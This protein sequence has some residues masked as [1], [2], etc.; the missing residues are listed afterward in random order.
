MSDGYEDI[1]P[2]LMRVEES[3]GVVYLVFDMSGDPA[4]IDNFIA[5][6]NAIGDPP[7]PE[8]RKIH[9]N[10]AQLDVPASSPENVQLINIDNKT[11]AIGEVVMKWP[12]YASGED[13]T[14]SAIKGHLV[15]HMYK[16]RVSAMPGFNT[17]YKQASTNSVTWSTMDPKREDK[18]V[19]SIAYL[20]LSDSYD[21]IPKELAL[22]KLVL[23]TDPGGTIT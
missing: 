8:N 3:N 2:N 11:S 16:C 12:V 23:G 7:R 22:K 6:H 4:V 17:S 18:A 20:P 21:N 13:C 19:Y 5:A 15:L 14:D 9:I 1:I 10:I